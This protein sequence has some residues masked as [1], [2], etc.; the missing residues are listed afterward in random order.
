MLW[1]TET[2][3]GNVRIALTHGMG[4]RRC[5]LHSFPLHLTVDCFQS[6]SQYHTWRWRAKLGL[7]REAYEPGLC[8]N[9]SCVHCTAI[10]GISAF[11]A[12]LRHVA[13]AM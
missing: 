11:H 2:G 1:V 12:G 4:S 13:I 6:D 8:V 5:I 10:M 3:T 9:C 7:D